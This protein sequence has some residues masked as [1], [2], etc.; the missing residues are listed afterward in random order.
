MEV[1]MV[2]MKA[3][4]EKAMKEIDTEKIKVDMEKAMK[5]VDAV[6]IKADVQASIAKIDWEKMNKE[7]QKVKEVDMAKIKADL[8]KMK[9]E[10]EKSMQEAKKDIEKARVEIKEYKT[11]VD[12]LEKD[13]LINKNEGYT[14]ETKN[15]QLIINGKAQPAEVNNKYKTFIQKHKN[16]TIKKTDDDFNIHKD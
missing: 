2:K 15:D 3:D 5:E 14:I 11:F 10:I 13:G 4:M 6:K 9:P 7:L 8:E 12:D 16:I 1:D